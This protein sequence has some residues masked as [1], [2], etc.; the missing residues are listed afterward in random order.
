MGYL[1]VDFITLTYGIFKLKFTQIVKA[2]V[3]L[4]ALILC[5]MPLHTDA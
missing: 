2:E 4:L 5:E 1:Q 3:T